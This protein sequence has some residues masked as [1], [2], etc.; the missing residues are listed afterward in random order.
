M[1]ERGNRLEIADHPC[2]TV[3]GR[4]E[5]EDSSQIACDER[6]KSRCPQGGVA[7]SLSERRLTDAAD[8]VL[9][10]DALGVRDGPQR[11]PH[12]LVL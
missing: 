7:D 11:H 2:A 9:R 10:G 12:P 5:K 6:D 4:D 8:P 3:R 1:S